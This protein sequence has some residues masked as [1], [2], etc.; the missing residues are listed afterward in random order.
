MPG[1]VLSIK[2]LAESANSS[3]W[4][5]LGAEF[6]G[7]SS[8]IPGGFQFLLAS[9]ETPRQIMDLLGTGCL[10]IRKTHLASI[11]FG[12]QCSLC[13]GSWDGEAYCR[14]RREALLS[15]TLAPCTVRQQSTPGLL[16]TLGSCRQNGM[17]PLSNRLHFAVDNR[18]LRSLGRP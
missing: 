10:G 12:H 17:E 7:D 8:K 14:W 3:R 4:G 11:L 5:R 1:T 6:L 18:L 16:G 15:T 9:G 13:L 2:I